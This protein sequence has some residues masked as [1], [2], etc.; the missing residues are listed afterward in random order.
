[1]VLAGGGLWVGSGL[2]ALPQ[3]FIEFDGGAV[4]IVGEDPNRH[5]F[6]RSREFSKLVGS[7]VEFPTQV[8]ETR[9]M[10]LLLGAANR[11]AVDG[12]ASIMALGIVIHLINH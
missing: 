8:N 12:H 7:S 6:S 1:M 5:R 2:G 11:L 3:F 10:K 9:A 4:L